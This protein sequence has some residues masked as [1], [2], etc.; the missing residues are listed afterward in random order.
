LK[1]AS[2]VFDGRYIQD[3]Y[4]GIGRYAYFVL[5]EVALGAP[6]VELFVLR[7]PS[8]QNTRFDWSGLSEL[9]NVS[10]HE[11]AAPAFG[12]R[13]QLE[14]PRAL[15]RLKGDIYHTPYFAL[16]WLTPSRSLITVHDCIFEH[17][18]RYMPKRWARLY[19]NL[20]MRY[21]LSRAKRVFVPSRA[22]ARDLLRFYRVPARKLAITTEAADDSFR[23]IN[24]QELLKKVHAAYDLPHMFILAVGARRPHKNFVRLV[25]AVARLREVE[26]ATLV[27]V[28]EVDERFRD[29]AAEAAKRLD[30]PVRFLGKVPERDL[31]V[32]YNLATVFACPSLMEGF[33]LPVLEAMACGT[34]VVCSAI[35]VFRETAGDAAMQIPPENTSEWATA[36][37]RILSDATLR[38]QLSDAGRRRA[39]QFSWGSAADAVLTAYSDLGI[40]SRTRQ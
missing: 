28:G 36:F 14:V 20:L 2:I 25:E 19:Y 7:D 22:T 35:P 31:S 18:A 12:S 8:L 23:P 9:P 39:A 1:P 38:T 33:G 29:D 6:G 34:P 3:R 5:R 15:A 13:E 40:M 32:L 4:H 26:G 17:D 16:P 10:I 37:E 30:L 24:D 11:I 21:S 27:L